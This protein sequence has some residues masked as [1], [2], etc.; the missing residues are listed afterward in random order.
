MP[1]LQGTQAAT[2]P[3]YVAEP[4][5]E[6]REAAALGRKITNS[7]KGHEIV[8]E[9]DR[10]DHEIGVDVR[11]SLD[12]V[13]SHRTLLTYWNAH[14][15]KFASSVTV[16]PGNHRHHEQ[17]P[18]SMLTLP[19]FIRRESAWAVGMK[20]TPAQA[21]VEPEAPT[22]AIDPIRIYQTLLG[23][24]K[25]GKEFKH[26]DLEIDFTMR[27]SDLLVNLYRYY[28][29]K[30]HGL[31]Y[32]T[33]YKASVIDNEGTAHHITFNPTRYQDVNGKIPQISV[34]K[35][36]PAGSTE[37]RV[38]I[39]KSIGLPGL[40]RVLFQVMTGLSVSKH[41]SY[42][43][44]KQAEAAAEPVSGDRAAEWLDAM[45]LLSKRH[46]TLSAQPGVPELGV[47]AAHAVGMDDPEDW[48]VLFGE[49]RSG[50]LHGRVYYQR[51]GSGRIQV[52]LY[53]T[54]IPEREHTETLTIDLQT[55]IMHDVVAAIRR[56]VREHTSQAQAAAEPETNYT[57]REFASM[58]VFGRE[59]ASI[60]DILSRK[61][62][63]LQPIDGYPVRIQTQ[64][65]TIT[66]MAISAG[67]GG[68][69]AAVSLRIA[70]PAGDVH[71]V[72]FV[73]SQLWPH[74]VSVSLSCA[75]GALRRE[76]AEN[77]P[78]R[79][80]REWKLWLAQTAVE[81][82]RI[83]KAEAAAEP[84]QDPREVLCEKL[85]SKYNLSLD[86]KLITYLGKDGIDYDGAVDWSN[87]N[88]T[89]IPV[90][91]RKVTGYFSCSSSRLTTLAGA[92]GHV[93]GNFNCSYNRL[94]TLE[95]APGHVGGGFSCYEN[96][97]TGLEHAPKHVVGYF[98][99]YHNH[100]PL[101]TKKPVGVNGEFFLG[102][103]TP[104][105][106][107]GAAEPTQS[108]LRDIDYVA[109]MFEEDYGPDLLEAPEPW[110]VHPL[111]FGKTFAIDITNKETRQRLLFAHINDREDEPHA[112]F[113]VWTNRNDNTA[114]HYIDN[115]HW[116]GHAVKLRVINIHNHHSNKTAYQTLAALARTFLK[117]TP[118]LLE[119]ERAELDSK[120]TEAAAE[121]STPALAPTD[122][123]DLLHTFVGVHGDKKFTL[124]C[125]KDLRGHVRV[126]LQEAILGVVQ[127]DVDHV[128]GKHLGRVVLSNIGRFL[129]QDTRH[130]MGI[131]TKDQ[132]QL[133]AAVDVKE[134]IKNIV[135]YFT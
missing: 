45:R 113:Q 47:T 7:Y 27:G 110:R 40:L 44:S 59:Q 76:S 17:V 97:L 85:K 133:L 127:I 107:H 43:L 8:L 35:N 106:V 89:R 33:V 79:R 64:A 25:A 100:L 125:Y 109:R 99:C 65:G 96:H 28:N 102:P 111:R 103:Q 49:R 39:T 123:Y 38:T 134:I 128:D 2:E 63:V 115:E 3:A 135:R 14:E 87:K 77:A 54:A 66:K 37:D 53:K 24:A 4:A 108:R 91:F 26:R 117:L 88:L 11:V 84:A 5:S 46:M 120:H 90:R 51:N 129:V 95:H 101:D 70:K 36:N 114:T 74:S 1:E 34:R 10:N 29:G 124:P 86:P 30:I 83:T 23:F 78:P 112:R 75:G 67:Q 50:G 42:N 71:G 32:Y 12:G 52:Q 19:W 104:A 116:S 119:Q 122:A 118:K 81:K 130:P 9:F 72:V 15:S 132:D 73:G 61:V 82:C 21:A 22:G 55:S 68:S 60:D 93:G 6:L 16:G 31:G 18:V 98:S 62:R 58:L 121:P 105:P 57:F 13:Y 92:P 131:P 80:M 41:D 20:P 126:S 48:F 56:I 69:N 94:T